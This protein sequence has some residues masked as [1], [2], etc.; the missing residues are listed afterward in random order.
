MKKLSV[1][2]S[3]ITADNDFQREQAAA[4]EDA[5]RRLGIDVQVIYAESDGI[6][7][8]QQ[9]LKIIQSDGKSRCDGI[10]F[11]PA[12]ATGLPQVALAAVS[13]G[14]GWGV[15]N[16][17]VDYITDLRRR[18]KAPVFSIAADHTEIG[19]TQG[20]Q[21]AA[22]LPRGGSVLCI[23]GP[24]QSMAAKGRTTGLADT[25]PG[26]ISIRTVRG[27]WT[28][29]SGHRSVAS[30]M[31]L[32]TSRETRY[33]AV[34]AQNDAMAMGARKAFEEISEPSIRSRWLGL[35]FLG[36]D[37]LAKTG[38]V[39][40]RSGQLTA[41]VVS[42]PMA[43]QALEMMVKALQTGINP[44]EHTRVAQHSYP[45]LED[46]ASGRAAKAQGGSAV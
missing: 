21:L 4:A 36:C 32:S 42:P 20:R 40:V 26:N 17:E 46:L 18:H 5:A 14:I 34:A 24:S 27:Q 1:V 19:R 22:L 37:G 28:R 30:W 11:E 23:E 25:T 9:L 41:T 35:P 10:L 45:S 12:G 15:L 29:E 8:S 3:L 44:A 16:R 7:Q 39:W 2:V 33:D 38:I 6:L 43:G 13:A 31:R